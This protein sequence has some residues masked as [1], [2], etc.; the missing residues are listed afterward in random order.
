MNAQQLLEM[1]LL[2]S[3]GVLEPDELEAFEIA[4]TEAPESVKAQIRREQS[5]FADQTQLLP[6]VEP[7]PELRRLVIDAVREAAGRA[8]VNSL[9]LEEFV[10]SSG[11]PTPAD[12]HQRRIFPIWRAA[13]IVF[14]VTTAFGA[15]VSLEYKNQIDTMGE[16]LS[17]NTSADFFLRFGELPGLQNAVLSENSHRVAF[18]SSDDTSNAQ[19]ALFSNEVTGKSFLLFK[20]LP[21]LEGGNYEIVVLDDN[22]E[23][24]ETIATFQSNGETDG[25]EF[26]FDSALRGSIGIA[27]RTATGTLKLIMVSA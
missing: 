22:N 2:D 18:V 4:F 10:R 19:A 21:I 14:A 23:M 24:G 9:S 8:T 27:A 20:R 1:A 13:A 6:N 17:T 7:R 26:G 25:H 12:M 16:Q 5:R 3:C 15:V 11:S